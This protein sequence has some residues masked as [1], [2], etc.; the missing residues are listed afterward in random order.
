M[1]SFVERVRSI[2]PSR[3]PSSPQIGDR[4]CVRWKDDQKAYVCRVVKGKKGSALHVVP[5]VSGE[6]FFDLAFDPSV[7]EWEWPSEFEMSTL[8]VVERSENTQT[9]IESLKKQLRLLKKKRSLHLLESGHAK[10][11]R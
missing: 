3:L 2:D 5:A 6:P 7:D 4:I 10:K 1:D 8:S 11:K 9:A